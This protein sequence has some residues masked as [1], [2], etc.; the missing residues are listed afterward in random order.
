[1]AYPTVPAPYGFKPVNSV[2]GKPYA[3]ATR[4]LRIRN[5]GTYDL[6]A[7]PIFY[8]DI[9][10]MTATPEATTGARIARLS[11]NANQYSAV[12]DSY[13]VFVG[14]TFISPVTKQPTF[15][16]YWPGPTAA[17][18]AVAYIVDDPM[19]MYKVV[20]VNYDSETQDSTLIV[21]TA[22]WAI[23]MEQA[24]TF[25]WNGD[26]GNTNTGN[27]Y[28]SIISP[29][30]LSSSYDP[31]RVLIVDVVPETETES[32]YVELYVKLVNARLGSDAP[33]DLNGPLL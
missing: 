6:P 13:G 9:V 12:A 28:M 26:E 17:P 3:G 33:N 31:R 21:P 10:Y 30:V 8:G 23:G 11:S 22:Y 5:T 14:C 24:V 29:S 27:S 2:D 16:Q 20:P 18:N 15:S 25:S 1:M 4:Q 32:G 7:E 19:A